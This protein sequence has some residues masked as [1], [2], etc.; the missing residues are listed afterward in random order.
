MTEPDSAELQRVTPTLGATLKRIL[1]YSLITWQLYR[2]QF[3]AGR[4]QDVFNNM[5]SHHEETLKTLLCTCNSF[6]MLQVWVAAQLGA[7]NL[8]REKQIRTA[9]ISKLNP[10]S[11]LS[12]QSR[13]RRRTENLF[14]LNSLGFNLTSIRNLER[15]IHLTLGVDDKKSICIDSCF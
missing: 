14:S 10:E 6:V 13:F 1:I 5:E 4:W 7:S 2:V 3:S 8:R 12:H 15:D 9:A 11:S